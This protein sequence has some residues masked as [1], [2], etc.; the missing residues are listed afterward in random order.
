MEGPL[1]RR[2]HYIIQAAGVY[3]NSTFSWTHE[4]EPVVL[5]PEEMPNREQVEANHT[6]EQ[7]ERSGTSEA[8]PATVPV[9]EATSNA[10]PPQP[11]S[12]FLA[13]L[14]Q[15]WEIQDEAT[16]N[17]FLAGIHMAGNVDP[18]DPDGLTFGLDGDVEPEGGINLLT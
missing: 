4:G 7:G 5:G 16:G 15:D 3:P 8:I 11:V 13:A 12:D 14:E 9:V 18:F 2:V 6:E 1:S 10:V 17:D